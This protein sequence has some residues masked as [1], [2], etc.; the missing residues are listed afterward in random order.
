MKNLPPGINQDDLRNNLT[1][2]GSISS[3]VIVGRT[4]VRK[5]GAANNSDPRCAFVRYA[6]YEAAKKAQENEVS[7]LSE[8][9]LFGLRYSP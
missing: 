7:C 6:T 1:S 3:V 9:V 5:R 8:F 2:Y 4:S